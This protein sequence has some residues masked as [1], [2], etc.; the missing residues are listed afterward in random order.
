MKRSG[1]FFDETAQ[2]NLNKKNRHGISLNNVTE[3]EVEESFK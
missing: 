1:S 2:V 3:F